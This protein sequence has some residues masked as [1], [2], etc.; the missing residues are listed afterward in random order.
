[1][2]FQQQPLNN[3]TYE[4]SELKLAALLLSEIPNCSIDIYEQGNSIRKT[5]KILYPAEYKNIVYKLEKNFINKEA[6]TNIYSYNRALNM[7]RD[8]LRGKNEN[9][10][11]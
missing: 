9:R 8:R 1:M 10:N 3:L 5:I 7:I 2:K 6:L 4:T 11:S